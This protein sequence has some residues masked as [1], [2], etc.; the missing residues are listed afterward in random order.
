MSKPLKNGGAAAV[1]AAGHGSAGPLKSVAFKMVPPMKA[2]E[3][4]CKNAN[5][6]APHPKAPT[7]SSSC[8][9]PH[10]HSIMRI[11]PRLRAEGLMVPP[12]SD[13]ATLRRQVAALQVDLE[14]HIDGEHRLQNINQQLRERFMHTLGP[15]GAD[16]GTLYFPL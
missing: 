10:S 7:P 6:G 4:P 2:A 15:F 11:G 12:A 14:A 16:L 13:A 9:P 3:D 5:S 1:A 8:A